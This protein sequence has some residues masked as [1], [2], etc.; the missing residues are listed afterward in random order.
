MITLLMQHNDAQ[1]HVISTSLSI[2]D[3]R[4]LCCWLHSYA[5]YYKQGDPLR[6]HPAASNS[7]TFHHVHTCAHVRKQAV[8]EYTLQT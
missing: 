4:F 6:S 1:C 3:I 8:E 7:V 2:K 5:S